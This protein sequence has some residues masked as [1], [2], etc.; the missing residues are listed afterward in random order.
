MSRDGGKAKSMKLSMIPIV[1]LVISSQ[2][3][4]RR[5]G[6]SHSATIREISIDSM[7]SSIEN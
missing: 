7:H 6:H 4:I 1:W 2:R 3:I 5:T